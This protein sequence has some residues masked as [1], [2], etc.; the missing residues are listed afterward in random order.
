[1]MHK[2][3]ALKCRMFN[4]AAK[5]A[6]NLSRPLV[7]PSLFLLL[8]VAAVTPGVLPRGALIVPTVRLAR[9]L[10]VIVIGVTSRG[11]SSSSA[12]MRRGATAIKSSE[13]TLCS[14]CKG[15]V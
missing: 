2:L 13:G 9:I 7:L 6:S 11:S 12:L 8:L 1:M 5:L 15:K 10:I 4:V 3:R 14:I